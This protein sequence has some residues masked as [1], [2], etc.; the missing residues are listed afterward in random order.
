M[1]SPWLLILGATSD[2]AVAA[3]QRFAK[4][5][6]NIYLASRNLEELN[7]TASDIQLRFHVQTNALSFDARDFESH[8]SFYADLPIKPDGV[9]LAFGSMHDQIKTQ[10][11][12][13]LAQDTLESNF[14]GAVSILEIIA[15]DFETRKSGFIVGISSVAG[16]RGR[17]SNYIYGSSKAALSTYLAG[18]RHRLSKTGISVLSVKPGFVRTKMT[19][20]LDLPNLLTAEPAQ[21]AEAVYRGVIRKKSTIYV[22][23]LWRIIMLII[24]H[25]PEFIFIKTKL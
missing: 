21:V 9:I 4:E 11:D 22:K 5:G 23:S 12:F 25:V 16:D 10:N 2:I 3:A 17:Q 24:T 1:N 6:Y 14:M 15:N 18:L 13:L 20:H 19:A 8:K 7:K